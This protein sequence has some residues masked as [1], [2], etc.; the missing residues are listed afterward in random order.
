[1]PNLRNILRNTLQRLGA[2]LFSWDALIFCFFCLFSAGVWFVQFSGTDSG[3]HE[4]STSS[5]TDIVYTEKTLSVAIGTSGVPNGE[6][7]VVFPSRITVIARVSKEE[8]PN[9]SADAFHAECAYPKHA[10]DRLKVTVKSR[11][12]EVASF[13]FS[14]EEVEYIIQQKSADAAPSASH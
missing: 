14:P 6:E 8:Y 12:R 3:K 7:L 5:S 13:R 10:T 2:F 11:N 4:L 1:M 9:L